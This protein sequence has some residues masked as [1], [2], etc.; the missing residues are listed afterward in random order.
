MDLSFTPEQIAFREEVRRFLRDAMPPHI[1]EKAAVDAHFEMSE[2]MEWHRVL[3]RQG[4]VA[5][6]FPAEHGGPGLDVTRRFLLTE[7][8][9]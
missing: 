6:H 3:Y 5:P 2:V 8:V 7:R 4:W 1:A 9:P